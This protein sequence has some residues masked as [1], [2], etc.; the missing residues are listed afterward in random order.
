M[1]YYCRPFDA[2]TD[3]GIIENLWQRNLSKVP[4]LRFDWLYKDRQMFLVGYCL[5]AIVLVEV[6][7]FLP[8]TLNLKMRLFP[9][10]LL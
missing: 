2:D 8:G 5:K 10:V 9:V 3:R 6:F 7:L 4:D 1:K